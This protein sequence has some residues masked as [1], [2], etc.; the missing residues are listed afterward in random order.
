MAVDDSRH[1][2]FRRARA[3]TQALI[4]GD[5]AGGWSPESA[6]SSR[7][8]RVLE[9]DAKTALT[10]FGMGS[11]WSLNP[12]G[13]CVHACLYCY[14]PDVAKLERPNWG[15]YV[16]VKRNLPALL[17]QELR[18][19]SKDEIFMSSATDPY[20]P[21]EGRARIT[22]LSLEALAR[23]PWPLRVLTRSPLVVRDI[24]LF[25][26]MDDVE[27]GLSIPTFDEGARKIL[28][29]H[30]P[31]IPARLKALRRLAEA[32]IS[33]YVSFAPAYPPSGDVTPDGIA[34]ALVEAG[35]PR[36]FMG[37]WNYLEALRGPLRERVRGTHLHELPT[38]IENS[39]YFRHFTK[40]VAT[41]CK[42][43]A[44]RFESWD[45]T[46]KAPRQRPSAKQ[47]AS[48]LPASITVQA[49]TPVAAQW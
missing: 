12:Y 42:K 2:F 27:V 16:L 47:A 22:R 38:L 26:S 11:G 6:P 10:P 44:I 15:S 39:A 23:N 29:P 36:V 14:V 35:V 37:R 17:S 19:K 3:Q 5:D 13:G 43:T 45:D 21:I 8:Y 30:A 24:D 33:T 32:G 34:D 7:R 31:P 18:A 1:Q 41:A 40:R 28:E 9:I 49:P 20:Q 46:S 25:R 4:E 48:P